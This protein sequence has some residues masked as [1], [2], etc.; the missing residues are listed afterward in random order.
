MGKHRKSIERARTAGSGYDGL[1]GG[2][3]ELLEHARRAAARSV[4]SILTATYWEI[5]RRIV[6]FEQGGKARAEY[7]EALLKNLARDLTAKCGRG[8]SERNLELM[9]AFYLG[10]EIA[11]TAPAQ[12]EARA[13]CPTP[14]DDSSAPAIPPTTE[15]SSALL[16]ESAL[17]LVV[18]CN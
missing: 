10:W 5:G 3:S 14:S 8:F 12:F 15:R 2:I 18:R 6:E 13:I 17:S 1:I 7:G 11:Q 4:N 16:A 9:R